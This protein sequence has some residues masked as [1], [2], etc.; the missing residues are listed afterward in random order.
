MK[1]GQ[2]RKPETDSTKTVECKLQRMLR[3]INNAFTERKYK[4]LYLN[5]SKPGAFYENAKVHKLRKGKGL[6]ELTLR[7][8]VS[9]VVAATHNTVKYLANLL[10]PLGKSD[11]T[12]INTPDFINRLKR[13]GYQE[14]IR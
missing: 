2:F 14:N 3:S 7:P 1:T 9:N 6:K 8:I 11:Y 12:I 10:A 5:S 13:K 4:R